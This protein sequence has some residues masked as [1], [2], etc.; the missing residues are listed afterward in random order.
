MEIYKITNLVN[1]KVYIGQSARGIQQRFTRH[2]Y[3]ALSGRIDTHFAR[4]IRKYG[5]DNFVVECIDN[6]KQLPN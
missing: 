1:G 4:A 5:E 2:I 6:N 3:D